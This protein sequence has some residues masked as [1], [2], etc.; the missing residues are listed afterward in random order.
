[1]KVKIS[2]TLSKNVLREVDLLVGS[3]KPR[4]AM[5]EFILQE[6]FRERANADRQA[7]DLVILNKAA[8]RLNREAADVLGYQA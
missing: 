1:M 3:N 8:D 7:R 4:S 2:I 6:Y 5:I